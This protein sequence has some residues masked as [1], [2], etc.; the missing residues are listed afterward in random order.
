MCEECGCGELYDK[1]EKS[2]K[3]VESHGHHHDHHHDDDHD[4]HHAHHDHTLHHEH[5]HSDTHT[6]TL[7]IGLSALKKN[8]DYAMRNRKFFHER[9]VWP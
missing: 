6:K 1:P 2:E 5:S 4:H 8:D 3:P 7:D 9:N